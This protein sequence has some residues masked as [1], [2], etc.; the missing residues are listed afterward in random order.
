MWNTESDADESFRRKVI[1]GSAAVVVLG[2]VGAVYYYKYHRAVP[3]A[4]VATEAPHPPAVAPQAATEPR[5][6]IRFQRAAIPSR[7][8]RLKESDPDVRASLVG[9]FGA[10]AISQ[11]LVPENVVRHI[12][13]TSRQPASQESR[14]R[15]TSSEADARR[16]FDDYAGRDHDVGLGEF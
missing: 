15:A 1:W 3:V 11:F 6:A 12:V 7:C 9:V 8:H 16:D 13:V 14:Y 5:F 10:K 4:P 2:L